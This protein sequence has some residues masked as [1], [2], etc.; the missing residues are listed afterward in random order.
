MCEPRPNRRPTVLK[1]VR[2]SVSESKE[3]ELNC[4]EDCVCLLPSTEGRTLA[5]VGQEL[6]VE[7]HIWYE[8][9]RTLQETG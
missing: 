8:V 3:C 4:D 9:G 2:V 5:G 1:R 6:T 7:E